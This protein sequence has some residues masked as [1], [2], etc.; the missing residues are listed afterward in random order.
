MQSAS[1]AAC[2]P[3]F[4]GG[5]I[6]SRSASLRTSGTVDEGART[7]IMLLITELE[8]ELKIKL[9]SEAG[10]KYTDLIAISVCLIKISLF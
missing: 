3:I 8:M 10:Y 9:F 5:G 1:N 4:H 7:P 2:S 6:T